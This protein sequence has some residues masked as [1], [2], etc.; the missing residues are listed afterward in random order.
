MT[1]DEG[2]R[3]P[4]TKREGGGSLSKGRVPTWTKKLRRGA[5]HSNKEK[6]EGIAN[7]SI[8]RRGYAH[9]RERRQRQGH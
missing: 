6:K 5:T 4:E 2:E 3:I 8:P 7:A 1:I 9:H